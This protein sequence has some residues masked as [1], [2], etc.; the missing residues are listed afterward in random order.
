M[1]MCS[2]RHPSEPPEMVHDGRQTVCLACRRRYQRAGVAEGPGRWVL[3]AACAG[4]PDEVMFPRSSTAAK[5][6][7][8][9]YCG[10]CPVIAE[11]ADYA[12]RAVPVTGV[13]GGVLY[14]VER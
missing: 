6:A 14:G 11:C 13:W 12:R 8:W 7:K 1:R 2:V 10:R 4:A 3:D 5:V 9:R